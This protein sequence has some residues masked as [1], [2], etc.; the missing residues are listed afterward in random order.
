MDPSPFTRLIHSQRPPTKSCTVG[1]SCSLAGLSWWIIINT[2]H[3]C[4]VKFAR[5]CCSTSTFRTN[6]SLCL[7]LCATKSWTKATTCS[8]MSLLT[9]NVLKKLFAALMLEWCFYWAAG[10]SRKSSGRR[11]FLKI[12]LD[13]LVVN[14]SNIFYWMSCTSIVARSLVQMFK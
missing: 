7:I 14:S 11:R 5:K 10:Y 3:C 4:P 13:L 6:C 8:A 12:T 1:T 2:I 9:A